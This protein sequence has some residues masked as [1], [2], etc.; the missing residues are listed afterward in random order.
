M[1]RAL[2]DSPQFSPRCDCPILTAQSVDCRPD[3]TDDTDPPT[4]SEI[5]RAIFK[6]R[7]NRA[8]GWDNIAPEMLKCA[9][10]P[11]AR[12]LLV[13]FQKVWQTGRVPADWRDGVVIPLYKGKGPRTMCSNYRP[14]SLLSVPSKVFAH[15]LLGPL[16]ADCRRPQQSRLTAGR[17]TAD[18][19]LALRLLVEIHAELR[20][21]LHVAYVDLKSAFDSLDREAFWKSL[22]G[23]GTSEIVLR[24]LCDL[25]TGTDACVRVDKAT[26]ERFA[27]SSAR[28]ACWL[29]PYSIEPSTESWSTRAASGLI[30][31]WLVIEYLQT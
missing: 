10:E 15:A 30:A 18:A 21:P 3:P 8:S 17:S 24:L 2:S 6:S 23:I 25:H 5:R 29:L 31:W 13:L 7:N 19:V 27:T 28:V 22:R 1:A 14:I 26:S 12:G 4:L 9:S 16:L 20:R 11:I